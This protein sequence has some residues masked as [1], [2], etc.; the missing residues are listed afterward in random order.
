MD[1]PMFNSFWEVVEVLVPSMVDLSAT[2]N[3]YTGS[4]YCSGLMFGM[5]GS[6][7]LIRMGKALLNVVDV[8]HSEHEAEMGFDQG[9]TVEV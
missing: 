6:S 4:Q 5:H 1:N 9:V 8:I 2:Q 3:G 7:L